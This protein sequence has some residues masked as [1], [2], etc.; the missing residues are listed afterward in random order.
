VTSKG[1]PELSIENQNGE[2]IRLVS[3]NVGQPREIGM[4]RGHPVISAIFKDPVVS[5]SLYLDWVNLEG[6]RQGDLRNHGGRDKAVYA[7][8]ADHFRAW[9]AELGDD[10]PFVPTAFGENLTVAGWNEDIVQIGDV[11]SWGGALLQ[12][13]QP[14]IPCFKLGIRSG[15]PLILKRFIETGRTGWYLR[16]IQPGDVPVAGP[17]HLV[18]HDAAS[19]TVRAAHLARLPRERTISEMERVAAV[20]ALAESWRG[21]IRDLIEREAR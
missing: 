13:V 8:S 12:V 1:T 15:R 16:V 21:M 17:I 10:P 3:V 4:H 2:A 20:E 5:G 14:R 6:D 11:W 9:T 7:Y 18:E 19:V